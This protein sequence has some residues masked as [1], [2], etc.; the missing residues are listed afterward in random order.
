M[1]WLDK[2]FMGLL[3]GTVVFFVSLMVIL[4]YLDFSN[5]AG[6]TITCFNGNTTIFEIQQT[7]DLW[8]WA[9][10]YDFI[11]LENGIRVTS[12]EGAKYFCSENWVET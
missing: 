8:K 5:H 3:I 2:F 11:Y 1:D 12:K 6:K 10:G 9:N 7:N 4:T